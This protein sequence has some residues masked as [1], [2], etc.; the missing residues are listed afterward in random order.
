MTSN[1]IPNVNVNVWANIYRENR[2]RTWGMTARQ[3]IMNA[4]TD[5]QNYNKYQYSGYLPGVKF[6]QGDSNSCERLDWGRLVD[7][8]FMEEIGKMAE[9][10]RNDKM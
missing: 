6:D 7:T 3:G 2:E 10:F 4:G 5:V 1:F 9:A 8:V